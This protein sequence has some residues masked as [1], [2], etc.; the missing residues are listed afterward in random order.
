MAENDM[1]QPEIYRYIDEKFVELYKVIKDLT[2]QISEQN[3]NINIIKNWER[4]AEKCRLEIEKKICGKIESKQDKINEFAFPLLMAVILG[5][6]AYAV[7]LHNMLNN[8]V[9]K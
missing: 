5:A 1:K 8:M 4:P 6:Y 7:I 2:A 3:M 9:G